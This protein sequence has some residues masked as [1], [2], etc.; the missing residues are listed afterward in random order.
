MN[1]PGVRIVG[2]VEVAGVVHMLDLLNDQIGLVI[3]HGQIIKWRV[4]SVC[5]VIEH[6]R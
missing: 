3:C 1:V 6:W 2:V 4:G 5:K